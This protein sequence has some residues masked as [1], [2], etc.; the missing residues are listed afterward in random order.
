MQ[1]SQLDEQACAF[2]AAS[3]MGSLQLWLSLLPKGSMAGEVSNAFLLLQ[4]SPWARDTFS[5]KPEGFPPEAL[6]DL[7]TRYQHRGSGRC[8]SCP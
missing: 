5:V 8:Q 2:E 3:F 4:N 1:T 6:S 7:S